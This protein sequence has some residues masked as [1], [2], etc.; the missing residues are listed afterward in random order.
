[1]KARWGAVAGNGMIAPTPVLAKA[2]VGWTVLIDIFFLSSS[3]DGEET[4]AIAVTI[5]A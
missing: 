4:G 1:M 3:F 2:R 5:C